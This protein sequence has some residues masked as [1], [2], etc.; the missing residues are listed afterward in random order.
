VFELLIGIKNSRNLLFVITNKLEKCCLTIDTSK[1][2]YECIR[3][4]E[5]Q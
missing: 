2:P 3:M 4:S 5:T 1:W